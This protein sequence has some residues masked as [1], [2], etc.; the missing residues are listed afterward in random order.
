MDYYEIIVGSHID[1]RRIKDFYGLDYK[2][3]P[4]GYTKLSGYLKDQSELF[5]VLNRVR[6]MNLTLLSVIKNNKEDQI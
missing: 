2:H 1:Q 4:E 5:S 6:D 3:L